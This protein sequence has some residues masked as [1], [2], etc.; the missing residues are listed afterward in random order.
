MGGCGGYGGGGDAYMS[1]RT[2]AHV[3]DVV[4]KENIYLC[5]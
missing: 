5:I 2:S 4:I 3:I 1:L